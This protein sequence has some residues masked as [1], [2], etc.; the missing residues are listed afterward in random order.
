MLQEA[1][2]LVTQW[3][4]H[5]NPELRRCQ[6]RELIVWFHEVSQLQNRPGQG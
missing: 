2:H 1:C 6:K 4:R 3:V 5:K